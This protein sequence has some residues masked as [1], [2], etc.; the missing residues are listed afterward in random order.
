MGREKDEEIVGLGAAAS[1]V[2]FGRPPPAYGQDSTISTQA[3]TPCSTTEDHHR[4][5]IRTRTG[6]KR[7]AQLVTIIPPNF[8]TS[9]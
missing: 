9:R 5:Q 8:S 7:A 2:H 3:R 4:R 6:N 1:G